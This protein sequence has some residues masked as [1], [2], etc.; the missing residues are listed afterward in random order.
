M[1]LGLA[2]LAAAG[3]GMNLLQG[4]NQMAAAEQNIRREKQAAEWRAEDR[5]QALRESLAA[6]RVMAV[7]QGS[8]A[9]IGSNLNL[10]RVSLDN[11]MTDAERDAFQTEGNIQSLRA[12]KTSAL[13]N[14][15]AGSS[16]SLLSYSS[17]TRQTLG[18]TP[19]ATE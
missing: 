7:G 2:L 8:S 11:F 17:A 5:R 1:A 3:V 16:Q 14:A 18:G 9:D 13:L 12:A 10:Q 4:R 15:I 6:Q 19:T